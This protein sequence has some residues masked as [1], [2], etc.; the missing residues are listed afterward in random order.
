[1]FSR[2]YFMVFIQFFMLSQE[3]VM[4]DSLF[5]IFHLLCDYSQLID[6]R[7]EQPKELLI[8]NCSLYCTRDEEKW[9]KLYVVCVIE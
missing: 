4:A 3:T 8:C 5:S 9:L 1:M 7:H 2:P 6:D